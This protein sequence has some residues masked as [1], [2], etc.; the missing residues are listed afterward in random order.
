M[1]VLPTKLRLRCLA[2]GDKGWAYEAKKEGWGHGRNLSKD[3]NGYGKNVQ[4]KRAPAASLFSRTWGLGIAMHI[5]IQ[6]DTSNLNGHTQLGLG[7]PNILRGGRGINW[8][9]DTY[10][11]WTKPQHAM[12]VATKA[13]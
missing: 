3:Q 10:Q 5:K 11:Y 12:Q 4:Q 1:P 6:S 2:W 9:G 8:G 13:Y 7:G